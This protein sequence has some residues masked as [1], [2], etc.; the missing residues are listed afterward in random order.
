MIIFIFRFRGHPKGGDTL[1]PAEE[2]ALLRRRERLSALQHQE[3]L[4]DQYLLHVQEL[5]RTMSEDPE[6]KQ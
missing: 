2:E 1:N 6:A 3:A 4:A 5:L